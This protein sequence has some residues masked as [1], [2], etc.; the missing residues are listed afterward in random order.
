[1]S[2]RKQ[3]ISGIIWT[4]CQQFGGQ[5]I[6]FFVSLVLARVLMP[7]EFGLIGMLS[8][9]IGVGTALFEGGFTSSLIRTN[10]VNDSDYST[11][12]FFNLV[13]SVTIYIVLYI[14]APYIADFYNQPKLTLIARVYGLTFIISAFGTVQNTILTRE[15]KFKKQAFINVPAL[16][17]SSFLGITLAYLNY[18]VWSLVFS[19]LC[20]SILVSLFL[21]LGTNWYP[22]NNFSRAKF[23]QHFHY[24]YKLTLSSLLDVVFTNIYQIIIGKFYSPAQV[25]Y[26][27]RA[28]SLMMLPVGNI[29]VALNKVVF[30][31]FSKIQDDIPKLKIAYRKVMLIVMFLV[32]PIIV[33]MGIMAE[34]LIIFLFTDRWLPMV[35]M[36]QIICI[37]GLL[38]PIHL[39]NL[40]ILQVKGRSDLFLKLEIIK[41]ILV[42]LILPISMYFGFYAIL[43]GQLISSILALFINTHFAG[44]ILDY[45][46]SSQLMNLLPI[47]LFATV[48][49]CAIYFANQLLINQ[50]N[51]TRLFCC[52]GFGLLLYAFLAWIFKF[53]S[54][55]DIKNLILKKNDTSY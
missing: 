35:P 24:G 4:Y 30:P 18:G 48:M 27:A 21:W 39:Y 29:S 5:V 54:L 49:G 17:I 13:S 1:M 37:T 20:N 33:I 16:L 14:L 11:V 6:T 7:T 10:E 22:K 47:F 36:F 31:I 53:E 55:I 45:N 26:Y 19:A 32:S 25:G 2:F 12:F 44:K 34:P 52:S 41:K 9:F 23:N 28:N 42:L 46:M 43:W 15:L 50:S 51:I 3:A 38:Y 8:I 40:I